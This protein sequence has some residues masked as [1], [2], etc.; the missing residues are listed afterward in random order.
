MP[1]CVD[2]AAIRLRVGISAGDVVVGQWDAISET[3]DL[4]HHLLTLAGPGE[5]LVSAEV[6]ELLLP[7]FDAEI[8]DLGELYVKYDKRVRAYRL[9]A[10]A[11]RDSLPS[12]ARQALRPS[13][14]V[15]PFQCRLGHD[16]AD[17]L[18]EAL[19]E[20][21]VAQLSHCVELNVISALSSRRLKGRELDVAEVGQ[22]LRAD[23]VL[24]GGY[25]KAP[26]RIKLN[27]QLHDVRRRVILAAS[28]MQYETSVAAAF[29]PVDPLADE[30]VTDIGHAIFSQALELAA[31]TP[32]P[33]LESYSLL[34]GAIGMMHR[35]SAHDFEKSRELLEHLAQRQGGARRGPRLDGQVA[36]AAG[37]ARVVARRRC[38][39]P[40]RARPRQ[41]RARRAAH[42]MR[43]HWRSAAWSTASCAG[44]CRPPAGCT[45]WHSP[46]ARASRWPGCSVRR[47][48]PTWAMAPRPKRPATWRCGCRRST[49]CATSSTRWP[50]PPSLATRTGTARWNWPA[51]RSRPT[52]PMH[53]RGARSSTRW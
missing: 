23:Y 26:D 40:A 6:Q 12:A 8:E 53:R 2:D 48:T 4:A 27:L 42:A 20:E 22:M 50:P 19:A 31:A 36:R 18:G 7:S 5:I 16:P 1:A 24:T 32:M 9:G 21:V 29:D 15:I 52:A 43:L 46:T 39:K 28:D 47:G 44:T 10:A 3:V 51:A 14:T 33:A 45:S 35:L 41:S 11:P 13:I 30:I 49:R 34:F 25:R 38:R 37:G 17:M